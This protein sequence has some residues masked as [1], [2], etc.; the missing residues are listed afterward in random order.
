MQVSGSREP[1]LRLG[2]TINE[3]ILKA[4]H[5]AS[6]QIIGETTPSRRQLF[7]AINTNTVLCYGSSPGRFALELANEKT[8]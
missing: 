2:A 3:K 1:P 4:N 7:R 8:L 5:A 6:M